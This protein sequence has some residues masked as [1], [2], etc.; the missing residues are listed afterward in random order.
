LVVPYETPIGEGYPVHLE[1]KYGYNL[2][3]MYYT[4]DPAS[5]IIYVKQCYSLDLDC[6]DW[7]EIRAGNSERIKL[8]MTNRGNGGDRPRIEII[9]LDK[10]A[11]R[12][13]KFQLSQD[14]CGLPANKWKYA[15]LVIEIP[16]DEK[17]G[18]YKIELVL[19]SAQAESLG[20]PSIM[21][22]EIIEIKVLNNYTDEIVIGSIIAGPIIML[23]AIISILI[24]VK[25]KKKRW[26]GEE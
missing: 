20:D 4:S 24:Q 12:G 14:K 19:S 8:N 9:N 11:D 18:E 17:P 2:S 26:S 25:R 13:W 3:Q 21:D 22:V 7:F 10:L 23:I 6:K 5:C 1:G 15:P 16:K